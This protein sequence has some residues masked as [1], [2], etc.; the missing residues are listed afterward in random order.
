MNISYVKENPSKFHFDK[1]AMFF[2]DNWDIRKFDIVMKDKT[3]IGDIPKQLKTKQFK[4]V[5]ILD[6]HMVNRDPAVYKI[7]YEFITEDG[8]K[9][10][11]DGYHHTD[12]NKNAWDVSPLGI[13]K[14]E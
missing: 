5:K 7:L 8:I 6:D 1:S 12:Y 4:D 11:I 14:G 3:N 13:R 10:I 2:D 9:I